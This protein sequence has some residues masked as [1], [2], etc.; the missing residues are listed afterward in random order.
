MDVGVWQSFWVLA[1]RRQ[2]GH[3]P[4]L[5]QTLFDF[6]LGYVGTGLIALLFCT[7]GAAV[8][9]DRGVEIDRTAAGFARQVIELY[10]S[11]LGQ[12]SRPIIATAAFT[13]MLSTTLTVLDGFPRALQLTV[14]RFF[15]PETAAEVARSTVRS[16]GF[17]TWTAIL[18]V[19]G[20]LIIGW[21]MNSLL[22]L[23]DLAT[24][25]SFVTGPFLGILAYR[26]MTAGSV[27]REFRPGPGLRA[28]AIAGIVFLLSLL[29]FFLHHRF[30]AA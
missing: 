2:T 13:A 17:W 30:I 26:A 27:P 25:L 10:T 29:A 24:I 5:R 8:I 18:I 11:T 1:R 14:R 16:R 4:T 21:S 28:M 22:G 23:V 19:G 15:G 20:L 3:A 6:R 12:W 9:F 7:L